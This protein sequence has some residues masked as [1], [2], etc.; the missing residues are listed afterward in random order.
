M[1][2][3]AEYIGFCD[4]DC[5]S[6]YRCPLCGKNFGSWTICGQQKNENGTNKYCPHCKEELDGLD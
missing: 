2:P 3:R 4:H 5:E 6:H 1:K